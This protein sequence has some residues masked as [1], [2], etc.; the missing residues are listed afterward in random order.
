[1]ELKLAIVME[2]DVV[3]KISL[4]SSVQ[5][6]DCLREVTTLLCKKWDIPAISARIR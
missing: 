6:N 3:Q 5:L 2:E 1:M 4:F